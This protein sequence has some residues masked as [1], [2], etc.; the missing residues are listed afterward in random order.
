MHG[1]SKG[2]KTQ[3][4]CLDFLTVRPPDAAHGNEMGDFTSTN[5]NMHEASEPPSDNLHNALLYRA[6]RVVHIRVGDRVDLGYSSSAWGLMRL[7]TCIH[8]IVHVS[9]TKH[10][11]GRDFH[12]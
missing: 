7:D 12:K 5:C 2:F 9:I 8:V 1:W 4:I 3:I 6:E 10:A 11:I